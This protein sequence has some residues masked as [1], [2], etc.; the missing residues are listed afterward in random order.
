MRAHEHV[1]AVGCGILD[2]SAV[3][4]LA[5]IAR[6]GLLPGE[7]PITAV[8]L[9]EVSVDQADARYRLR[10]ISAPTEGLLRVARTDERAIGYRCG[11]VLRRW[12]LRSPMRSLRT[13][14]SA[15]RQRPVASRWKRSS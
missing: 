8:T 11:V 10:V 4:Q 6:A 13:R 15:N 5:R 2:T 14:R 12:P 1:V 9:G 3:I 7:R